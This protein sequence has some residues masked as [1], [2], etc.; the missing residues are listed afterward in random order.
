MTRLNYKPRMGLGSR[1]AQMGW[2]RFILPL[3]FM[4]GLPLALSAQT[5]S[6][7]VSDSDGETLIGVNI[8]IKGTTS[9]TVTDFDGTYSLSVPNGDA[10]LVFRAQFEY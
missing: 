8:L 5:I 6:G 10:V 2:H 1:N 4:F 7:T 9:G 3:F